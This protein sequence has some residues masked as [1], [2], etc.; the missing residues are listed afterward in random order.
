MRIYYDDMNHV[1]TASDITRWWWWHGLPLMHLRRCIVYRELKRI[2]IPTKIWV[3]VYY[4][5]VPSI[6]KNFS[7]RK[8]QP[9]KKPIYIICTL[10]YHWIVRRYESLLQEVFVCTHALLEGHWDG[11]VRQSQPYS[12][13]FLYRRVCRNSYR[14]PLFFPY[15]DTDQSCRLISKLW[16]LQK[17]HR[18]INDQ[19]KLNFRLSFDKNNL[20]S[21]IIILQIYLMKE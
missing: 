16:A 7:N 10:V 17:L 12:L 8:H 15:E 18:I 4:H 21:I 20:M 14:K 5:Y 2:I 9:T 13:S 11:M 1:G 3:I 19:N 6:I